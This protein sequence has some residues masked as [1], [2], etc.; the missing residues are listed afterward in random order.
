MLRLANGALKSRAGCLVAA[1]ARRGCEVGRRSDT[2][3]GRSDVVG[4]LNTGVVRLR[5]R[6][7]QLVGAI[8]LLRAALD[9]RYV[10]AVRSAD[11]RDGFVLPT[12]CL[13]PYLCQR[14]QAQRRDEQS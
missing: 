12:S 8:S 6:L 3:G 9:R 10:A 7:G 5:Q 13:K 4:R 14:N 1:R 11:A 2:V